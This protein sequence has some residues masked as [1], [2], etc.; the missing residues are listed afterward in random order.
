[1]VPEGT[2]IPKTLAK[3]GMDEQD[4]LEILDSQD[5]KC[6]IC[7]KVPTTGR[8]NIDHLHVRGYAQLPPNERR[9]MVRGI[10]CQWCNRSFLAKGMTIAKAMNMVTYLKK[11]KLNWQ[12]TLK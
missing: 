11:F 12:T 8:Y 9:R 5:G 6:P 10:V 7:D 2:R 1:M 4:F 3:Y